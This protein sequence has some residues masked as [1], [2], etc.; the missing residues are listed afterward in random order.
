[1]SEFK[2]IKFTHIALTLSL[3]LFCLN[4]DI[5][6][7]LALATALF[8]DQLRKFHVQTTDEKHLKSR[9]EELELKFKT[10]EEL[11]EDTKKQITAHSMAQGFKIGK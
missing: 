9:L 8:F 3:I 1:M 7:C 11:A 2:K 10:I 6:T 4:P 5:I